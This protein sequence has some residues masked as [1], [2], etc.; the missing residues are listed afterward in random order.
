MANENERNGAEAASPIT[1]GDEHPIEP[2]PRPGLVRNYVAERKLMQIVRLLEYESKRLKDNGSD[3]AQT[4]EANLRMVEKIISESPPLGAYDKAE[5]TAGANTYKWPWGN[6]ET[7]LLRHLADAGSR[8]WKLYDLKDP[9]TAPENS[10][11]VDWLCERGVSGRT[12]EIMATILRA[13]HL[14]P[15]PRK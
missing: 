1:E 6:H 11:V 3:H 14:R 13:D 2:G 10:Q 9:S 7:K 12:A 5:L 15:G 4:V 8:F